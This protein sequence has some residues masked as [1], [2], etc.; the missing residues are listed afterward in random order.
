M[1][2]FVGC[3]RIH[4]TVVVPR[5]VIEQIAARRISPLAISQ[6]TDSPFP[7]A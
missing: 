3:F 1:R 6:F 4:N 2:Y 7:Q 5:P